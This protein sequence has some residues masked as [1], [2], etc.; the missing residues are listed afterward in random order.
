MSI[1]LHS[2]TQQRVLTSE[3]FDLQ[4][5]PLLTWQCCEEILAPVAGHLGSVPVALGL[6]WYIQTQGQH[7][8]GEEVQGSMK[9]V[10][11]DLVHAKPTVGLVYSHSL[12][13]PLIRSIQFPA[14]KN[15]Q[16]KK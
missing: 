2:P 6:L 8:F 5:H 7:A 13:T 10:L 4:F 15:K 11:R 12:G 16:Q 3:C 9:K 1:H 14:I